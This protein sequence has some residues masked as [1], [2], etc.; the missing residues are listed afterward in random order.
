MYNDSKPADLE[1]SNAQIRNESLLHNRI[2]T[3]FQV[4]YTTMIATNYLFWKYGWA[5]IKQAKLKNEK[6]NQ[7]IIP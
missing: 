4:Y 3:I 7:S 6:S 2:T 5:S 1:K